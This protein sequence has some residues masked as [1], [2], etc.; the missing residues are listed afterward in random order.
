M[1]AII[2]GLLVLLV[3]TIVACNSGNEEKTIEVEGTVEGTDVIVSAKTAGDLIE[4]RKE[5]GELVKAGDTVAALEHETASIKL[6]QAKANLQLAQAALS[7][8]K[9]GARK[10]DVFFTKQKFNQAKAS[11][12]LSRKEAKRIENL[13]KKGSVTKDKLDKARTQL[14]IAFSQLKAAKS[15]LEK[16]KNL[17][18]PEQIEEAQARVKAA[19]AAV[20]LLKKNINDSYLVAPTSGIIAKIFFEKGEFVPVMGSVFEIENLTRPDVK[21]YIPETKLGLVKRGQAAEI[22]TDSYPGKKFTGRVA[23]ISSE[24]EFTPKTIQ[25]K[26]ERVK[27]VYEV[28]IKA[29][30]PNYELKSGM[31]V[32]VKI[33]VK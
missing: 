2:K 27:L 29:D 11:Y 28:K 32:D 22:F 26:E 14:K 12:E 17:S 18:R 24:A 21:V 6:E 33:I 16:I 4:L 15:N 8:L 19:E 23:T 1:K 10:E 5:E 25:T 13:Y 20:R 9:N 30:N 3:F 31:P 7:L